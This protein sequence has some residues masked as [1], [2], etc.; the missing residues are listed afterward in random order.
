MTTAKQGAAGRTSVG[1]QSAASDS[2]TQANGNLKLAAT[3]AASRSRSLKAQAIFTMKVP[4]WCLGTLIP[5]TVADTASNSSDDA[6]AD[7]TLAFL[8]VAN[9]RSGCQEV[10]GAAYESTSL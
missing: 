2:K 1:K 4:Q 5:C 7:G 8:Q 6:N 3:E 9:E 10:L